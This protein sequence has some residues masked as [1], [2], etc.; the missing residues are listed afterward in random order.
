MVLSV[1]ILSSEH[2]VVFI[3]RTSVTNVVGLF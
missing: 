3:A 2:V 1:S